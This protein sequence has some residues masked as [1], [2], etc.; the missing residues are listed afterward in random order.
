MTFSLKST[1][2]HAVMSLSPVL[3]SNPWLA[4]WVTTRVAVGRGET[5]SAMSW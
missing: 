2:S 3:T 1:K 5:G 4:L